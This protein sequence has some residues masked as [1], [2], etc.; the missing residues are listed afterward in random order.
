[1]IDK[2]ARTIVPRILDAAIRGG[3][4]GGVAYGVGSA[5]LRGQSIKIRKSRRSK[6]RVRERS[7]AIGVGAAVVPSIVSRMQRGLRR[8]VKIADEEKDAKAPKYLLGLLSKAVRRHRATEKVIHK[9]KDILSGTRSVRTTPRRVVS[10]IKAANDVLEGMIEAKIAEMK[11]EAPK[12]KEPKIPSKVRDIA[13]AIRRDDKTATD[14]MA[15]KV[16]WDTYKHWRTNRGMKPYQPKSAA[17]LSPIGV[18]KAMD[19][20]SAGYRKLGTAIVD[21]IT[22]S[23]IQSKLQSAETMVSRGESG[24][25]RVIAEEA[26]SILEMMF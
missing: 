13:D 18:R 25:G 4:Y 22:R 17:M 8:V 5:Q 14:E 9:A 21:P 23:R 24:E 12:K 16:A 6:R 1:M 11:K 7:L 10:R 20:I 3:I 26:I 19:A 2:E 15:Y